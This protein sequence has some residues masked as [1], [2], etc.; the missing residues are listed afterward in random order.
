MSHLLAVDIGNTDV[1][2]AF[3]AK[4]VRGASHRIPTKTDD[5]AAA[6]APLVGDFPVDRAV[7][8]SVVPTATTRRPASR[9]A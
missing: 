5:I 8:A 4:G 2:L 6:L 3:Y 9:A 7:I 1:A